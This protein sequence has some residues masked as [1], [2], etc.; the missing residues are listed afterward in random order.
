MAKVQI[1]L[2]AAGQSTR[3]GRANKLLMPVSG[4]P[5]VRRTAEELCGIANA[6]ITVVL[7]HAAVEVAAAVEGLGVRTVVN[8]QHASG[9]M[10]SVHTG[11]AAAG[12]GT[13]FMVVPADM[14]RLKTVDC[15]FLLDAHEAAGEER[16]TVPVRHRG[17]ERQRGNPVIMSASAA[18]AVREGGINLGCRG[19]LDR[20]PELLHAYQ[21]DRDA[22]FVDMD[23]PD[24]YA[25]VLAHAAQYLPAGSKRRHLEWN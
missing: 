6:E 5:L 13:C 22:F 15:L 18:R 3:M 1:I 9:Q 24:S 10:S 11:I 17:A 19:L 21:T 12:E 7:G 25:D 20:Q 14:P 8:H 2:L 23:T 4:L 16:V